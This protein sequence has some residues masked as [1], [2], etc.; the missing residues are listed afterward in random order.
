VERL[1]WRRL[2]RIEDIDFHEGLEASS[3]GNG[4]P[5]ERLGRKIDRMELAAMEWEIVP[6]K[7]NI[8]AVATQSLRHKALGISNLPPLTEKSVQLIE[9][10]RPALALF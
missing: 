5:K 1:L 8:R 9:V 2:R 10:V 7:E 4:V 6:N 3:V